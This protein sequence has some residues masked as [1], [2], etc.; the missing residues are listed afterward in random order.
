VTKKKEELELIRLLSLDSEID[1]TKTEYFSFAMKELSALLNSPFTIF[2]VVYRDIQ[3]HKSQYSSYC[4]N[5]QDN[6]SSEQR[7]VINVDEKKQPD[8]IRLLHNQLQEIKQ[9]KSQV[10]VSFLNKTDFSTAQDNNCYVL[11]FYVADEIIG[12]IT[13]QSDTSS[14]LI[15]QS[16]SL[17]QFI[18]YIFFVAYKSSQ[19]RTE[20]NT[21]QTVLN[22]MP[23]RV[24]WKNRES[25]YLGSNSAFASDAHLESP[26]EIVGVTDF[27]IFP[28]QAELYRSDDDNT[29]TSREHL[30]GS[31]E[32]QTHANGNTIWLRTSK[33]PI[34]NEFN[35]VTGLVGTYD[36][37]SEL[38]NIQAELRKSQNELEKKVKNRTQELSQTNK[39]LEAAFESLESAQDQLVESKKLTSLGALV[40]GVS[41]EI[42]TPIGIAV[43]MGST[44][45]R[46]VSQFLELLN[47]GKM[48]RSDLAHF[49]K[50]FNE[51]INILLPSLDR[52]SSLIHSFKQVAVDQTSEVRRYFKLS[53]VVEE[54][55]VTWQHQIKRTKIRCEYNIDN[56]IR[57]DSFPGPLGQIMTNLYNNAIIHAFEDNQSGLIKIESE[58]SNTHVS[59][60]IIDNGKG[61]S[62]ENID[63][64]FDPFYTTT[65]GKGGSGLGLNIIY[66]MVV[67]LMGG[68][69]K[70]NSKVD[71]G[72]CFI[73]NLPLIAPVED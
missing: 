18:H 35:E 49:E 38:K 64:I 66:N 23:Q 25:V 24:F 21:L 5:T 57:M 56:E 43:T 44:I 16:S 51:G 9:T 20:M 48:R 32:P 41:H 8:I 52:A 31:E 58:V 45:K 27:D 39:K 70:V 62:P 7:V 26:R 12:V 69:I 10:L 22:L 59:I 3:N 53:E 67:G 33:R 29:M 73:L 61:I 50:D 11:P 28:E 47:T 1:F 46:N 15:T 63:K 42:N 36:D 60:R 14:T 2:T 30:I 55:V 19:K 40:A 72:T 68:T 37:I 13:Y 54:V 4:L 6:E 65:L 34:I 17:Y 71:E